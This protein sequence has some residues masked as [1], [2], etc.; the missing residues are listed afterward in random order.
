MVRKYSYILKGDFTQPGFALDL[1]RKDAGLAV[2]SGKLEKVPLFLLS[3]DFQILT[4]ASVA[5]HGRKDY[6]VVAEVLEEMVG[7]KI[8]V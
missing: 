1:L 6:S 7:I 5:G 2:E 4:M 8:R 3:E